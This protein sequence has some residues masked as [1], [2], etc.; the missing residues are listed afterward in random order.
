MK[1]PNVYF[2][3]SF[4]LMSI[5]SVCVF[6]LFCVCVCVFHAD[7]SRLKMLANKY[8]KKQKFN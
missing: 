8:E 3:T 2:C 5:I 6:L 7:L 1:S 4:C